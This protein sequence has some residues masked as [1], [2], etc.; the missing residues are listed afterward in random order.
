MKRV[1]PAD[2]ADSIEYRLDQIKMHLGK[3]Q[4]MLKEYPELWNL[5]TQWWIDL[6]RIRY[7]RI[8]AGPEPTSENTCDEGGPNE[9]VDMV[10]A[11]NGK[12]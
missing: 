2:N 9:A 8:N 10:S 3:L 6:R 7:G 11:K 1:G 5:L 12:A 4:P